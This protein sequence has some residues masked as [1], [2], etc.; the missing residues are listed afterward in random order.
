MSSLAKIILLGLIASTF[1]TANAQQASSP[2]K[3]YFVMFQF[4]STVGLVPIVAFTKDQSKWFKGRGRK[5]YPEFCLDADKATYVMVTVRWDEQTS[6]SINK[7]HTAYTTGPTTAVVGTTASGP[8]KPAQPI[9]GTQL[10]TFVTTWQKRETETTQEPHAAV[11]T[12]RPKD[13]KSLVDTG[14]L[15]PQPICNNSKGVGTNAAKNAFDS[16]LECLRIF[17]QAHPDNQEP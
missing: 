4:D 16:T 14:E 2:C 15:E 11:L 1:P 5:K 13:G 6:H 17:R 7:T 8:G 3:A 12:F 9:W 10:S